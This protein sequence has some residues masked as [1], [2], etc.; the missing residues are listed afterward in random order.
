MI[1]DPKDFLPYLPIL[2]P[3]LQ[4]AVLDP[5]PDVRSTSG[6]A[7]GSLTRGLGEVNLPELR[8]WL[9]VKL[10]DETVTS[11]ERS[12]AAQGLTEL[13]VAGG[14]EVVENVI[15]TEILPLR[16]HPQASTREGVLWVLTFLPSS[17]GQSFTPL[18]DIS[19]PALISGLSD[20]SEPV[21][22]VAMRAGRVIIRTH[23]K[24]HVNKI[25]PSLE[26]GLT[27]E[28]YRIRVAS[29][30][31]LGDLLSM[32]GGTAVVKGETET[33]EDIRRAEKAQAQI[34]L[35]LG[36]DTRKR[37]LSGLYL[38]RSDT[39]AVVR[40][41]A[42]QVWKTV[43][44]VTGRTLR[45]IL[46]VLVSQ[47]VDALASGDPERTQVAG[48]CLGDIVNKLGD[49]VLPE[50]IPVLRNALYD[51][52]R[53]TRRGVCVGLSEVIKCS[54]RDQILR[55]IEIIV[56]V[57]QDA[58]CDEDEG[59]RATAATCFSSLHNVVG[60][61]AMDEIV[62]SLLVSL[63]YGDEKDASIVRALNGLTGILSTRSRELLPYII[64]RLL[65]QPI[66]EN[67]AKA[68]SGIAE[69]TSTTLQMHFHAIIPALISDLSARD[70]QNQD[71]VEKAVRNCARS[72]CRCVDESGVN[73]L[74]SE[75]ASKCGSDK[76]EIRRESCWMFQTVV[77]ES[78]SMWMICLDA[79]VT[80]LG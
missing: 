5:I 60:S 3:D 40:Q 16:S 49:S 50:I 71:E 51:G 64:P 31:L 76:A 21:R 39:T 46:P 72:V 36:P 32:I 80:S 66:S 68:L 42:V 67:H 57:V 62:P 22:E 58:L 47:I 27:D 61:R 73:W 29:L 45:D 56:K 1:N 52:D 54:T 7:I 53:H 79:T 8:T 35:A 75:I 9:I 37:V 2:L 77:E 34:A 4:L 41:S 12:G 70:Q 26:R 65:K 25:L 55:F 14:S 30:T 11:A 48:R 33:Q 78:K 28:D 10:R 17:M 23:G 24:T 59:V 44:S 38:A 15:E 18:I 69:V 43:V 63:E 6:K 20:E 74:V 13:L 19:L